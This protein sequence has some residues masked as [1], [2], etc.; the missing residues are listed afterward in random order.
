[1]TKTD[2]QKPVLKKISFHSFILVLLAATAL[3]LAAFTYSAINEQAQLEGQVNY[4]EQ[5]V[6]DLQHQNKKQNHFSDDL[7]KVALTICQDVKFK[8]SESCIRLVRIVEYNEK[9]EKG[10]V[11]IK[12]D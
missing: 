1:M 8:N 12:L 11:G 10:I 5:I 3:A 4:L 2:T 9:L 6:G 7:T